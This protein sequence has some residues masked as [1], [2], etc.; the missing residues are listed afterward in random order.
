[1]AVIE[2]EIIWGVLPARPALTMVTYSSIEA[3]AGGASLGMCGT[4]LLSIIAPS[5][6]T[7]VWPMKT[8]RSKAVVLAFSLFSL[9]LMTTSERTEGMKWSDVLGMKGIRAVMAARRSRLAGA[10]T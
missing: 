8:S 7:I 10:D 2:A 3:L 1:M 5:A 6:A 4:L 9:Q